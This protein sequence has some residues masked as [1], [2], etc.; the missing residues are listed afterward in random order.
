MIY[1]VCFVFGGRDENLYQEDFVL[2]IHFFVLVN[3]LYNT[4]CFQH[5]PARPAADCRTGSLSLSIM[6]SDQ[7]PVSGADVKVGSDNQKT[8]VNKERRLLKNLSSQN[9]SVEAKAPG[10]KPLS[11]SQTLQAGD[12]KVALTMEKD[13]PGYWPKMPVPA[14]KNCCTSRIFK[15]AA[16]RLGPGGFQ[17]QGWAIETDP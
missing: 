2:N 6:D 4:S 9:L 17:S 13:P 14:L 12:N 1:S 11:T 15:A 8:D 3:S 7:K 10:Y 16:A 5:E